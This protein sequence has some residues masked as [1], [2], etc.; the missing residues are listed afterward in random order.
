MPTLLDNEAN[1][2]LALARVPSPLQLLAGDRVR[3]A[4]V[5]V[6]LKRDDLIHPE[7]PGNKWRKLKYYLAEA[8]ERG[9][10]TLLTFG[11]VY[12]NHIRAAAAAGRYCGLPTIGIIRGEEP[13]P[14]NPSLASARSRQ[15][16][17]TP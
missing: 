7:M 1:E 6:W 3:A 15:Q 16:R 13:R 5:E 8:A 17:P 14:P 12:S 9:E 4:G 10:R 2:E 11:G